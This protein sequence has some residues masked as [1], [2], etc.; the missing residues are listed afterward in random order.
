MA[1]RFVDLHTHSSASDGADAPAAL[2]R[3]AVEDG[4]RALA[5][6][7]HDTL[8]GLAE[9]GAE[10]ERLGLEFIRG[11]EIAARRQ[12]EELHILGLWIPE[13]PG[14]AL[15]AL[16]SEGVRRREE[17]N[18]AMLVKMREFGLE[19][20]EA[21]LH[22]EACCTV[23]GRPHMAA[24]LKEKHYVA[25]RREAFER[26]LGRD[27]AAFVPRVLPTPEEGIATLRAA[28]ALTALAHP[29]LY[30]RMTPPFLD[31]CLRELARYGL[32]AVEAYHSGHDNA[33]L[34]LCLD[35]AERHGLAVTGGSDYH[36]ARKPG[37]HLGIAVEGMPV[38]A[39]ILD[40]L[41]ARHAA[42]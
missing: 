30:T 21:D 25:T 19:I 13:D 36:G 34:R 37:L 41:K 31:E 42:I 8:D 22:G 27:G 26:W 14:S 39:L 4:L 10:A 7:D 1:E 15:P 32:D 11:C 23:V 24:V 12:G 20:D 6:T 9:A 33:D 28:G 18:A 38:P 5:L 35:L 3:K 16:L 29:C 40:R 17:R 2:V